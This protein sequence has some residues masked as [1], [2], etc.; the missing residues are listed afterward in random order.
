[1]LRIRDLQ[2]LDVRRL[3]KHVN[4]ATD[5]LKSDS[6]LASCPAKWF[7]RRPF[8]VGSIIQTGWRNNFLMFSWWLKRGERCCSSTWRLFPEVVREEWDKSE[9]RLEQSKLSVTL[10]S[11]FRNDFDALE[12]KLLWSMFHTDKWYVSQLWYVSLMSHDS[13]ICD[14]LWPYISRWWF[15]HSQ[16]FCEWVE[17]VWVSSLWETDS[18]NQMSQTP[19]W[20]AVTHNGESVKELS[21]QSLLQQDV[22]LKQ[23][24]LKVIDGNDVVEVGKMVGLKVKLCCFWFCHHISETIEAK[25]FT[26]CLKE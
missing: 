6:Q 14:S 17:L 19:E 4:A 1:M 5:V 12:L 16:F 9:L 26:S 18:V 10:G 24:K 25:T 7:K 11:G 13:Q 22:N 15:Y 8:E 23:P 2:Q 20:H 3:Q 21:F